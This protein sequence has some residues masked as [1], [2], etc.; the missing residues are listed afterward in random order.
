MIVLDI[1]VALFGLAVRYWD[2]PCVFRRKF[3]DHMPCS[4]GQEGMTCIS[5]NLI[6]SCY[7]VVVKHSWCHSIIHVVNHAV[8]QSCVFVWYSSYLWEVSDYCNFYF[9]MVNDDLLKDPISCH[10]YYLLNTKIAGMM[11]LTWILRI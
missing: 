4:I 7:Q 9:M 1:M 10:H 3:P 5:V 2:L 11:N 6:W 8:H